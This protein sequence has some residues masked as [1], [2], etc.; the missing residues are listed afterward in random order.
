MWNSYLF[1][2]NFYMAEAAKKTRTRDLIIFWVFTTIFVL[3]DGVGGL[4]SNTQLAIDGMRHLGFPDFFRIEL[5]V[6]KVLGGIAL[7]LPMVPARVKEWAYFGFAVSTISAFIAYAAVDGL[8]QPMYLI[9][10]VVVLGIELVSYV[11]YHK[12]KKQ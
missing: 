10:P 8:A 12:L 1:F 3:F 11:F 7:M 2:N 6:A 5:G 4:F 9:M